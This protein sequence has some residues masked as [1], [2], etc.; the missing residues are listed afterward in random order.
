MGARKARS[1]LNAEPIDA[2][3]EEAREETDRSLGLLLANVRD[4]AIFTLDP[5]GVVRTWNA[6]A[7]R[8]KGYAAHEII[9][10]HFSI[11]YEAAEVRSGKPDWELVVAERD[12]RFEDEAWRIRKDGSKFWA[13]VVITALRD[14]DGRLRGFGKVTRDNTEK[15]LYEERRAEQQRRRTEQLSQHAE[16]MGELERIKRDFLN[17]ASHELRGPLSVLRGYMS[18]IEDGTLSVDRFPE[19]LPLLS[20]KLRQIELLVS[21]MLDTARLEEGRLA[22]RGEAFDVREMVARVVENFRPLTSGRLS[23]TIVAP[24]QPVVLVADRE[25]LETVISN[26]LDNAIKYSPSGGSVMGLVAASANRVFVSVRDEGIGIAKEDLP[27]LFKPFGRI[28]TRENAHISGVGLGLYLSREIVRRQGGDIL[29][30]STI[31]RGSRFTV[32]LPVRPP[33]RPEAPTRL[34]RGQP[35]ERPWG[36]ASRQGPRQPRG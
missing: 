27:R 2:A 1:H 7:Q 23:L 18:M 3:T 13:N 36:R 10:K 30:E 33:A 28:V 20:A 26:L 19:F 11:F 29:V 22:L 32:T 17:L 4:Y 16:R 12:G 6:G 21:Q 5:Q 35:T 8:V 25:R 15:K 14:E 24:D 31:D 9:G 34:A